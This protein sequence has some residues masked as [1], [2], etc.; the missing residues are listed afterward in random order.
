MS[1]D[2]DDGVVV[3]VAVAAATTAAAAAAASADDDDA[4]GEWMV[5]RSAVPLLG[6]VIMV[7]PAGLV[8]EAEPT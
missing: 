8:E 6:V 7:E 4:D 1:D 3:V 2:E 5:R